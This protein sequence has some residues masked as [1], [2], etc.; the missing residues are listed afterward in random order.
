LVVAKSRSIAR[1]R[2]RERAPGGAGLGA[3]LSQD[4]PHTEASHRAMADRA[5]VA[6]VANT[7]WSMVRYRG[8]LITG[9]LERGWR[10][11]AIADFGDKD[12]ADLRRLGVAPI[13]LVVEAA[14][15]NPLRDLAYLARLARVLRRLRPDLV[16]NFSVK[17]VIYGS[18]GAKLVGIAGIVNSV[19]GSGMLRAGEPGGLQRVLRVLYRPALRGRP[20]VIFQNRDDLELFVGAGLIERA[21]T[22]YIAGSGVDTAAL[23]PDWSIPPSGRTCFVMASRMLWSKGIADFVEAARMMK[24]RHPHAS[25]VLFGG[26]AQD[27][28]SKNPDFIPRSWLEDLN[29]EGVVA[30]RGFTEPA[31]VE[32]A[33]RAAAAVVLPSSYAEGVPRTLIEAAAA[34]AP[35]IT[36]DTPGCRDTV[37]D[38]VSGFLCSLAAPAE[39]AAAMAKLLDEPQLI[40]EMG[41]AGRELAVSR[42]DR[43]NVIEQ[44]VKLYQEQLCRTGMER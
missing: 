12:L 18:L 37:I 33:M 42:F 14:G 23:A 22:V 24:P 3:V 34:G 16:H 30:W 7:G 4:L 31:V 44:T 2:E 27:Y 9:L 25:F 10:V 11:S 5:H 36:T 1:A 32:R 21:H 41:R 35:I 28:G 13:R 43:R 6:L 29:R 17:P 26:S 39:L 19:T 8:E 20:V 15:Q 40:V 38:Q